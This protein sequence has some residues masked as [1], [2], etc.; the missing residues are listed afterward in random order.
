MLRRLRKLGEEVAIFSEWVRMYPHVFSKEGR[1]S[2]VEDLLLI[3][4][5]HRQYLDEMVEYAKRVL[6]KQKELENTREN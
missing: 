5:M 1:A 3:G 2:L 4:Q 6:E